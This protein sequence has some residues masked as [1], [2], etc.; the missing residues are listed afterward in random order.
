LH[1]HNFFIVFI[2]RLDC[3][4][5]T[6]AIVVVVVVERLCFHVVLAVFAVDC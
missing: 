6:G 3:R 1:K 4:K 5:F 2:G